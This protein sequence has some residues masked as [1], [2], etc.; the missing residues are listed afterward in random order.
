MFLEGEGFQ[1]GAKDV[2]MFEKLK[3]L[4]VDKLIYPNVYRWVNFIKA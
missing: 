3:A 1:K 4:N 2:E